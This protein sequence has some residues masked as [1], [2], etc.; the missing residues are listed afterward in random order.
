VT[1]DTLRADAPGF[2]GKSRAATP[3]LDRMASE[4]IVFTDAHAHNVITLPSHVNILTGLYPYQHGVRDNDGFCLEEKFPTLAT[5]LK[6]EGYSTGAFIGA[7]PLDSRFGL[8]RGFDVYDQ[9]Y[10][11]G[12]HAYD[13]VMA[14]RSAPEVIAAAREWLG[15]DGGGP[16]FLWVHLYDCHFPYRPPPPFDQQYADAPYLGEVAG[17]DAALGPLFADLEVRRDRT[18]LILTG[19]HGEALGD[20]GEKTHGIFAY[21]ATL[22]VPLLLWSPHYL[23]PRVDSSMARHIDIFPTVREAL[24][25]R[26]PESLPGVS[27]L[28][29]RTDSG[30]TS[31]FEALSA[32]LNRGWAPLRGEIAQG[33]KFIDL[34]VPELYDLASDPAESKNEVSR[35]MDL[36]RT[37]KGAL[38]VAGLP[39]LGAT[40]SEDASR[41]RSLGY[42]AGSAAPKAAYTAED[43]PKNLIALDGML[44]QLIG[45]YQEGKIAAAIALAKDVVGRRPSMQVGYEFLSF[46]Q[47]QASDNAAAIATLV[48]ASRRGLASEPLKSRLGLLYAEIGKSREALSVLEPLAESTDPDVLNALGIARAGAGQLAGSLEAF[49]RALAV[50]PRNA[51]AY[52]NIGLTYLHYSQPA[53]A[54]EAFGRAF[55]IND[56]LPRAWNGQGVALEQAGRSDEAILA[57]KRAVEL[58]P[59]QFD[60]LYNIAVVAARRGDAASARQALEQFIARAPASRY[61]PDIARARKALADMGQL[62]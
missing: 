7:F 30:E 12:A 31:Y 34:P 36:V 47:A 33:W 42:L 44:Q 8:S 38:P 19:D 60:A 51:I 52:Q 25:L 43:D 40:S 13:F 45:L 50:D 18:L 16:L 15:K 2:S 49:H 14:E 28:R 37:L 27:L 5:V 56:R 29:P 55:Q 1:I 21:E 11:Q 6:A 48:E 35:R 59:G 26:H 62:H 41:L 3:N 61:G 23:P 57:W 46:L 39:R 53:A 32:F 10:P 9:K 20:H 22:K 58:D 24:H 17:V 4:G 54:L